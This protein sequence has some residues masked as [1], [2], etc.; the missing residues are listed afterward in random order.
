MPPDSLDAAS[1]AR[2]SRMKLAPELNGMD[3]CLAVAG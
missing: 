1:G 3:L 2:S